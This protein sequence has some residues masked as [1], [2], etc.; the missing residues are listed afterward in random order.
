MSRHDNSSDEQR[1][2]AKSG[3]TTGTEQRV[4]SKSARAH[5]APSPEVIAATEFL[6][7]Q[8]DAYLY[9]R[10]YLELV[11]HRRGS[12]AAADYTTAER[13][14]IATAAACRRSL[15]RHDSSAGED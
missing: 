4:P 7:A 1:M 14:L 2:A 11:V 3:A 10:R 13:Y 15:R 5:R 9:R 6:L 12:G 8:P